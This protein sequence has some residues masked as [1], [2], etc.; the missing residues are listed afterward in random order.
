V[1]AFYFSSLQ[2]KWWLLLT[3]LTR[4][5]EFFPLG[6]Q[7]RATFKKHVCWTYNFFG[8][9]DDSE[10][11]WQRQEVLFSRPALELPYLMATGFFPGVKRPGVKLTIHVYLVPRLRMSG[12]VPPLLAF[13]SCARSTLR[14]FFV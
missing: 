5:L 4:L 14:F 8:H 7:T 11:A 9:W 2:S 6:S 1:S 13:M 10:F 12:A 3:T